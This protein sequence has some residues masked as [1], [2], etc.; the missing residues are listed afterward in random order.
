MLYSCLCKRSTQF[1]WETSSCLC[2][3]IRQ[4]DFLTI[5]VYFRYFLTDGLLFLTIH[6]QGLS[7][8]YV[9]F[10]TRHCTRTTSLSHGTV[11]I[12]P[13]P[14]QHAH[15]PDSAQN[16]GKLADSAPE[17]HFP[18]VQFRCLRDDYCT[19]HLKAHLLL[20]VK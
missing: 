2:H 8:Q 14:C 6:M 18:S 17:R 9:A 7:I 15:N 10:N 3:Y 4:L 1:N 13:R 11:R 19:S 12:C 20:L 16:P 5:L